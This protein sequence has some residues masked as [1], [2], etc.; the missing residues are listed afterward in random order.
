MGTRPPPMDTALSGVL[1]EELCLLF[2]CLP[3]P[4]PVSAVLLSP[5]GPPVGRAVGPSLC[6]KGRLLCAGLG[7]SRSLEPAQRWE[8]PVWPCREIL[9]SPGGW[10]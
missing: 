7:S 5:V 10:S 3:L 6:R 1:P 4:R 2:Q 8:N 9:L